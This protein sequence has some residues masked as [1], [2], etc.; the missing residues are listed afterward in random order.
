MPLYKFPSTYVIII[1]I[2]YP[3]QPTTLQE[4]KLFPPKNNLIPQSIF[5]FHLHNQQTNSQLQLSI[6]LPVKHNFSCIFFP[7]STRHFQL[8][9][10]PTATGEKQCHASVNDK[11]VH[12]VSNFCMAITDAPRNSLP[13]QLSSICSDFQA[14]TEFSGIIIVTHEPNEGHVHWSHS[15]VECL[16]VQ[17]ELISITVENRQ[18]PCGVFNFLGIRLYISVVERATILHINLVINLEM[19]HKVWDV[20]CNGTFRPRIGAIVRTE[21]AILFMLQ[22]TP[23]GEYILTAR[24]LVSA[25]KFEGLCNFLQS[26]TPNVPKFMSTNWAAMYNGL[27]LGTE[28]MTIWT[29][30]NRRVHYT[31]TYRAF[32]QFVH[33]ST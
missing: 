20:S 7:Y 8:K 33:R 17:A 30:V 11:P 1:C 32:K 25:R 14:V 15:Y 5:K 3:N 31:Q 21:P 26:Q 16:K 22:P 19:H 6:T 28:C 4:H 27:A 23:I 29:L 9:L 18:H 2:K 24:D 12:A 10:L 13:R